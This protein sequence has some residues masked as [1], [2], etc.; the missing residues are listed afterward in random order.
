MNIRNKR[1]EIHGRRAPR[2]QRRRINF[3]LLKSA[4]VFLI[5]GAIREDISAVVPQEKRERRRWNIWRL[6]SPRSISREKKRRTP[7]SRARLMRIVGELENYVN[8]ESLAG[9]RNVGRKDS[10]NPS[11]PFIPKQ[12][13]FNSPVSFLLFRANPL[14]RVNDIDQG[15]RRG[16]EENRSIIFGAE[17]RNMAVAKNARSEGALT[18][19][20][21][22]E[23]VFHFIRLIYR[24]GFRQTLDKIVARD[25]LH[26][27]LIDQFFLWL[28]F[29]TAE[30][31]DSNKLG[32]ITYGALFSTASV[33]RWEPRPIDFS[34]FMPDKCLT[35]DMFG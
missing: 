12:F 11:I 13:L 3:N 26:A 24:H 4:A 7:D 14:Q 17:K 30:F 33:N 15:G 22:A 21:F 2:C 18:N 8:R 35:P 28:R 10:L 29:R 23:R 5:P 32:Q 1:S 27:D 20:G 34:V 31:S 25:D 19:R 16:S 9:R 6:S